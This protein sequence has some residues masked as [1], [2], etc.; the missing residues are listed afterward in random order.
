MPAFTLPEFPPGTRYFVWNTHRYTNSRGWRHCVALPRE[1]Q[2]YSF[3]RGGRYPGI[4]DPEDVNAEIEEELWREVTREV[5][6]YV[7]FKF[8]GYTPKSRR[9]IAGTIAGG[10]PIRLIPPPTNHKMGAPK[11]RLP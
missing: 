6:E 9:V 10:G 7:L 1:I 4:W 5:F 11:G 3:S 2:M 8:R